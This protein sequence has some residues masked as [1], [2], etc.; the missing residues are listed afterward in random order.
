MQ[1]AQQPQC[2]IVVFLYLVSNITEPGFGHGQA[3]QLG[4]A[5][6]FHQ[7]PGNRAARIVI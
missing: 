5:F 7:G 3:R 4:I 2:F 1:I 6:R